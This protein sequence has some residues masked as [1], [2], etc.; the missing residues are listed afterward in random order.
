MNSVPFPPYIVMLSIA[1]I[2]SLKFFEIVIN[3]SNSFK[4]KSA[5]E[6][7][8]IASCRLRIASASADPFNS[9]AFASALAFSRIA[10]A[11]FCFAYNWLSILIRSFAF[12]SFSRILMSFSDLI[13]ATSARSVSI[14]LS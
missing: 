10:S 13:R 14:C 6:N 8:A 3:A 7:S 11:S 2:G 5:F 12:A 1:P 4:R 9:V